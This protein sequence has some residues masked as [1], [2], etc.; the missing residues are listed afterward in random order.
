MKTSSFANT[1]ERKSPL[2]DLQ[3]LKPGMKGKKSRGPRLELAL[4]L[5]SLIDAFSII[6]IYLLIG[7]QTSGIESDV[8][9]KMNLPVAENSTTLDKETT[10]L[11]I[12]KGVYRL[13]DKVVSVHALAAK[14]AE[15]KN[16]STEKT[17]EL[18]VQADQEMKY[19]DLDPL[20]K[21]SSASGFEKMR[22]AVVPTK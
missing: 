19:Q 4:P 8:P 14:L 22:F 5:T 10:T 18:V 1:Q 17:V 15:I 9:H 21:A 3:N 13:N 20:L 12:Q 16:N 6:V 7:T 2:A 11:T